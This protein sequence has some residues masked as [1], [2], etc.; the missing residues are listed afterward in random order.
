MTETA[1][2][3]RHTPT[4]LTLRIPL[5]SEFYVFLSLLSVKFVTDANNYVMVT[6]TSMSFF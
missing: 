4:Y 5:E 6:S 3:N 1:K 2:F